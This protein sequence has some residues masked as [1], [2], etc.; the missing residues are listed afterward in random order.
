MRRIALIIIIL[1]SFLTGVNGQHRIVE[2]PAIVQQSHP[3]LQIEKILFY[4]DSV[5]VRFVILNKLSEGGWFCADKNTYIED[6][7]GFTRLRVIGKSDIPWCPNAHTF[8]KVGEELHFSLIFPPLPGEPE[9]LNIIE[10]CDKSCFELKGIILSEKLNRDL[11][12]FDEAMRFYSENNYAK[13]L[14]LF[15]EIVEEIPP[16]PTHVYGYSFYNLARICWEIGER[17]TAKEWVRQLE[18]S[19][20]PNSQYF[21]RNLKQ[22][23]VE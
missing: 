21:L 15:G 16:K 1:A 19:G 13:A 9:T 14:V 6:S 17:D 8:T 11:R 5:V 23:L 7:E 2:N 10:V 18:L 22:E 20:L 12:L 4:T 3:E